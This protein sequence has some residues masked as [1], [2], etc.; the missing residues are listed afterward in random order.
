MESSKKKRKYDTN[1]PEDQLNVPEPLGSDKINVHPDVPLKRSRRVPSRW[2]M[3]LPKP[4]APNS[5]GELPTQMQR[6]IYSYLASD[7][8]RTPMTHK[9]AVDTFLSFDE[10]KKHRA[11]RV[12]LKKLKKMQLGNQVLFWVGDPKTPAD[13]KTGYRTLKEGGSLKNM[14]PP[15]RYEKDDRYYV[16]PY[17]NIWR[18]PPR[19]P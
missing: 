1:H 13:K 6:E 2:P 19:P 8:L 14:D 9:K 5:V 11:S 4:A 16:Y 10:N 17:A 12:L 15:H 7:K 3:K 18:A